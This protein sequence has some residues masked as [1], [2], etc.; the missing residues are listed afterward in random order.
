MVFDLNYKGYTVE[1]W[2]DRNNNVRY[3]IWLEEELTKPGIFPDSTL[4]IT[5][6]KTLL[7]GVIDAL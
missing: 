6:V 2:Q 4:K 3:V 7:K 5:E 1:F